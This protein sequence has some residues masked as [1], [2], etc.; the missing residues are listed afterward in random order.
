MHRGDPAARGIRGI[1][2]LPPLPDRA[3]LLQ[4][5]WHRAVRR[6][7]R[8]RP[9]RPARTYGGASG[10]RSRIGGPGSVRIRNAP[11]SSRFVTFPSNLPSAAT[12]GRRVLIAT[13]GFAALGLVTPDFTMPTGFLPVGGGTLNYTG[14][15]QITYSSLPTDG[16]TAINRNGATIPNL[17]TN[18]AGTSASVLRGPRRVHS[19]DRSVVESGRIRHRLQHRHQ[20]RHDRHHHIHL[21]VLRTFGVVPL[22]GRDDRQQHEVHRHARQVSQ[23][24][25]HLVLVRLP[26]NI[27]ND[28]TISITFTSATTAVVSLPNN[29]TTNITPLL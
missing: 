6:A 7:P 11:A 13:P 26:T 25:M 1:R 23:R 16:V 12:A 20:A 14:A 4:C 10:S 21:R 5:R 17:A 19:A 22:L 15:D 24:S 3:G 8:E 9:T 2:K 27:G 29:R 28:G 18:F